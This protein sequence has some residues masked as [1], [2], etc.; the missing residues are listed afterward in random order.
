MI[1]EE[2]YP[3]RSP[4]VDVIKTNKGGIV[5]FIQKNI[6]LYTT[7]TD[8]L[9]LSLCDGTR[10]MKQIANV[11]SKLY[12]V[13]SSVILKDI[14]G[15]AKKLHDSHIL[16]SLPQKLTNRPSTMEDWHDFVF[17][18]EEETDL[19]IPNSINNIG[20][21]ITDYCPYNCEY[22]YGSFGKNK[23]PSYLPTEKII[24]IINEA[25]KL[26]KVEYVSIAG[27]DPIAHPGLPE[28]IRYL[29]KQRIFY[30]LSTKGLLL[31]ENKINELV[32]A[33]MHNIQISIDSWNPKLWSEM[34]GIPATYFNNTIEA[35][36]LCKKAN[37]DTRARITLSKRN[38][39]EIPN[40]LENLPFLGVKEIRIVTLLPVG[41]GTQNNVPNKKQ[42]EEIQNIIKKFRLINNNKPEIIF[43]MQ[44]YTYSIS[45]GGARLSI[46]IGADGKVLLCDVVEGIDREYY[47]YGNVYS[48]S[49]KEIWFSKEANS[50]RSNINIKEC[51]DCKKFVQ[52]N[53]GCRALAFVYYGKHNKPDPRC[54]RITGKE[55]NTLFEWP[56]KKVIK[57]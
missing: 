25:K 27:G 42:V 7:Q 56:N 44:K 40:L 49:I 20:F 3:L 32:K 41:E 48:N 21:S 4:I 51:T 33:G 38:L 30:E 55:D 45:C 22:C 29:E 10:S 53:G 14:I 37:V 39:K 17:I 23:K 11:M 18:P 31:T 28:I 2:N 43:G 15:L 35:F 54:P 26:G 47:S 16:F 6:V 12:N 9:F 36:L 5:K 24:S 46:Q 13:D 19:L 57:S 52:C 50:L 34:V 1:N 8:S